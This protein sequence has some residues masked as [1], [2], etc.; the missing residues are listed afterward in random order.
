MARNIG[1]YFYKE[2]WK[3]CDDAH[4][5]TDDKNK[6]LYNAQL[7]H[8]IPNVIGNVMFEL[9][10]TY[11]GLLIG[12][13]YA[14]EGWKNDENALKLGFYFDYTSGVPCLPGSSIKGMLNSA[15]DDWGYVLDLCD[16]SLR[17]RFNNITSSDFREAIFGS[18][19]AARSLYSRVIFHDAHAV[20]VDKDGLLGDDYITPH[21]NKN[22]ISALDEFSNPTP[23]HFLKVMPGVT[24]RFDFY[25]PDEIK[26]SD[27]TFTRSEIESIFLYLIKDFGLGAKT[28]VGYG[29]LDEDPKIAYQREIDLKNKIEEDLKAKEAAEREETIRKANDA[30]LIAQQE[31]EARRLANIVEQETLDAHAKTSGVSAYID[32]G[33]SWKI[34]RQSIDKYKSKFTFSDDDIGTIGKYL[35]TIM[36]DEIMGKQ[37]R[38]W[39]KNGK[40]NWYKVK[41]WVGEDKATEWFNTLIK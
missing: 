13:G 34:V 9:I 2:Y 30:E 33:K 14:H 25:I 24:F 21:K 20:L 26:I 3:G 35:K 7:P 41:S 36:P 23:I 27:Q 5:I 28:N 16:T 19:K 6:K 39:Q 11:P 22:N 29:Y 37:K 32:E 17:E 8:Y 40:G 1:L 31:A 10:T 4:H 15:I 38:S 18:Q 12:S